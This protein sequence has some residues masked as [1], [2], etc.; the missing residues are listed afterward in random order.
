MLTH[1]SLV[2]VIYQTDISLK[3]DFEF[4]QINVFYS[5]CRVGYISLHYKVAQLNNDN[6][7]SNYQHTEIMCLPPVYI[8]L[9]VQSR[10]DFTVISNTTGF[11]YSVQNR[12]CPEKLTGQYSLHFLFCQA[13][14]HE[15]N[16]RMKS[17][18]CTSQQGRW[19]LLR[20]TT[21]PPPGPNGQPRLA[22]YGW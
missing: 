8:I 4:V 12:P 10:R 14:W 13:S 9:I 18:L 15:T 17:V 19:A 5:K 1:K 16:I 3:W 11:R 21:T 20:L 22:C 2:S 6:D 7:E